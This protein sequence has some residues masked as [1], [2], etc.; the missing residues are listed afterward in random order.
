MSIQKTS[1]RFPQKFSYLV[2]VL[3]SLMVALVA[4]L[5]V[6]A[7]AGFSAVLVPAPVWLGLAVLGTGG[8]PVLFV[9]VPVG[10]ARLGRFAGGLAGAGI[11]EPVLSPTFPSLRFVSTL[12]FSPE[13]RK[14]RLRSTKKRF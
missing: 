2:R 12:G 6:G 4:S 1:L 11:P 3:A 10:L 9:P 7:V 8:L 5:A 14:K 13:T